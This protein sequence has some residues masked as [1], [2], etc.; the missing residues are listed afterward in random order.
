[1]K[2][3]ASL[4]KTHPALK[5]RSYMIGRLRS[6]R[7]LR[8]KKSPGKPDQRAH[9]CKLRAPKKRPA[10]HFESSFGRRHNGQHLSNLRSSAIPLLSNAESDRNRGNGAMHKR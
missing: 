8:K 6:C 1:M 3:A 7:C 10:F 9:G 2:P 4:G 5:S